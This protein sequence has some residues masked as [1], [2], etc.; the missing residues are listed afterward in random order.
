MVLVFTLGFLA[1]ASPAEA[2]VAFGSAVRVSSGRFLGSGCLG[3]YTDPQGRSWEL[4]LTCDHV[5][6]RTGRMMAEG[7]QFVA[8]VRD[9]QRDICVA[10]AAGR[11]VWHAEQLRFGL[12]TVGDDVESVGYP[13]EA[14]A[15]VIRMSITHTSMGNAWFDHQP[16]QGRSGSAV[17]CQGRIVG[18]V[19]FRVLHPDGKLDLGGGPDGAELQVMV[20]RACMVANEHWSST[21]GSRLSPIRN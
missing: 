1:F 15:T 19:A 5:V 20:N 14:D 13:G 12:P 8:V 6:A 16:M 11:P 2:N 3:I 7:R 17:W 4:L 21:T 10:V 9:E 18:L